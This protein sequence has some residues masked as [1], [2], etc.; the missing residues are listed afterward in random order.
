MTFT[1]PPTPPAI[2]TTS[3]LAGGTFQVYPET[4]TMVGDEPSQEDKDRLTALQARYLQL[5]A[6]EITRDQFDS[7]TMSIGAV[8]VAALLEDAA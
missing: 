8:S 5:V 7:R 2:P 3:K 6:P 1:H 4:L